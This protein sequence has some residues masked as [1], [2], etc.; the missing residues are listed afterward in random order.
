MSGTCTA[1]I[2]DQVSRAL[3]ARVAGLSG[4]KEAPGF[5]AGALQPWPPAPVNPMLTEH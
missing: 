5:R 3:M 2:Q 4:A 1:E